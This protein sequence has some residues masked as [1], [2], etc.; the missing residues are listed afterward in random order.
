MAASPGAGDRAPNAQLGGSQGHR[1]VLR[2]SRR[3]PRS[4]S[5]IAPAWLSLAA[6]GILVL[7]LHVRR[8]RTFEVPSIQL[9][10]LM[11]SGALSR[12]RIR[13][14]SPNLL[15]LLQ[16]L[17]VALAALALARPVLGPGARFVHEIVLL[18]ASG[19]RRSTDVAPSRFDAAVTHLAAMSAGSIRETGAR[20][21]VILAGA[22]PQILAAR[23]AD[24]GGLQLQGLRGGDGEADWAA[25]IRLL[26]SLIKDNEPTRLTLF[27]DGADPARLSPALPGVIVEVRT[28]GGTAAPNAALHASLRA[29]DAPAGKWRAEGRVAF[30]A[31][32]VGS[33]TVT[34]LVQPDGSAGF[35]QWGSVEVG[36]PG[37][38]AAGPELSSA[39]TFALD[40]D[41][42][43]PSVVVLRLPD[44][45]GPHDN[46]VNFVVRPKPR[47]LK[48]LQLGA[49][50]EPLTRALRA[51][52]EIELFAADTLPADVGAFDLVV[53]K[54][55]EI[56]RHPET[57]VL[58]LGAARAAGESAGQPRGGA[59]PTR[60][61]SDHPRSRSI[62]W[63]GITIATAYRFSHLQGAETI[64][65]AGD[66]P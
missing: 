12:R 61:E 2:P 40:L 23:L 28:V 60:W 5:L 49:A 21:S 55:I 20:V 41:L 59:Q 32:F 56:T 45:S 51:A 48:V 29:I 3:R 58:W 27:T 7:I 33:T 47:V 64:I 26:S 6:F 8:R 43:V 16:L 36:P 24:P 54:G 44:D 39:A 35:L 17:I 14:P 53:V 9:W 4:M 37:G 34:A 66:V 1:A 15:L 57:N 42:R 22:R 25:V 52:A 19:S 31:G 50:S 13:L 30:S 46:A 65:E 62:L 11:D 18:D 63:S 38:V 10:R